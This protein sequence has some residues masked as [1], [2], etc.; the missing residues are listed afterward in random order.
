MAKMNKKLHN[1]WHRCCL[2]DLLEFISVVFIIET[3]KIVNKNYIKIIKYT[4]HQMI[5]VKPRFYLSSLL[6]LLLIVWSEIFIFILFLF[7]GQIIFFYIWNS[8]IKLNQKFEK[9][10]IFFA[11]NLPLLLLLH[12]LNS[13]YKKFPKFH[14]KEKKMRWE[15]E[16]EK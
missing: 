11:Y 9:R 13:T 14:N 3:E 10:K 1:N 7:F 8:T 15:K 12:L 16:R 2:E 6:N 5:H 4:Q